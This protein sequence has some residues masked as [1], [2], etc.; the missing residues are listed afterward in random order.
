M[1]LWGFGLFFGE[2]DEGIYLNRFEFLP[3]LVRS[4]GNRWHGAGEFEGLEAAADV[5]LL[6][7]AVRWIAGYERWVLGAYGVGYRRACLGGWSKRSIEPEHLPGAWEGL[8]R[9][10]VAGQSRV[11]ADYLA[12]AAQ[13]P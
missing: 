2:A 8:A 4:G 1:R 10:L 9:R 13:M 5:R 7:E 11:G 6:V 12:Q 3:R